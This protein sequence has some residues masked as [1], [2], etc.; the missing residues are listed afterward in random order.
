V[1]ALQLDLPE[2]LARRDA[3]LERATFT[4]P[5]FVSEMRAVAIALARR[6]GTVTADDLRIEATARGLRPRHKNAWGAIFRGPGWM[7]VGEA[8][9]ALPSNHGHVNPVW[10]WNGPGEGRR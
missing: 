1:T 4:H 10:T 7:K 8:R 9:S 6:R 5:D 3:G 2:G